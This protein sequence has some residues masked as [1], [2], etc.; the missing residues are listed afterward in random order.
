MGMKYLTKKDWFIVALFFLLILVCS[1]LFPF[2][3]ETPLE[4]KMPIQ[5]AVPAVAGFALLIPVA[6]ISM[7]IVI[8]VGSVTGSV[9]YEGYFGV[10][11]WITAVIYSLFLIIALAIYNDRKRK[12]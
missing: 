6:A 7:P 11:P 9:A 1:S 2:V 4:G 5:L 8:I 3:D 12:K 10:L